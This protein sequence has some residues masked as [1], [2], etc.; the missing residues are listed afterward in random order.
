MEV[1]IF[2]MRVFDK[3]RHSILLKREKRSRV[4]AIPS[5]IIG[6]KERSFDHIE[7]MLS[8][9]S[10]SKD[11]EIIS[12]IPIIELNYME[13]AED[14]TASPIEMHILV[15]DVAYHGTIKLDETL[16]EA[17]STRWLRV[18][19]FEKFSRQDIP[20]HFLLELMVNEDIL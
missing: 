1:K 2:G 4:W 19:S 7:D 12:S 17:N 15:H 16:E 9:F 11:F 3:G 8:G 5:R 18:D 20:T 6:M 14:K 10:K 13:D